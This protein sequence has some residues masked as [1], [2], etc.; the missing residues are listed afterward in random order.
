MKYYGVEEQ[1]CK[2]KRDEYEEMQQIKEYLSNLVH[3]GV[4]FL[5]FIPLLHFSSQ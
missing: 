3:C 4:F 1:S 5:F 2:K